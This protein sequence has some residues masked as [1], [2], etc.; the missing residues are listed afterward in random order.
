M[1]TKF[2]KYKM[3]EGFSWILT[4]ASAFFLYKFISGFLKHRK[5]SKMSGEEIDDYKKNKKERTNYNYLIYYVRDYMKN[6]NKI[7]F[8]ENYLYYVF[9][10]GE[11]EIKIDKQNKTI[12]WN[13]LTSDSNNFGKWKVSKRIELND[14]DSDEYTHIEPIPI[15]QEEIDGLVKAI[16][17][18]QKNDN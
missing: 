6:D 14:I 11:L 5:F 17:E 1:V 16:K 7:K 3:N 12:F 4:I 18:D 2:K 10:L 9:E 13:Y 15:S 8:S